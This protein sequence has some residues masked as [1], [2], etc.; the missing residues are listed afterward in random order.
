MHATVESK[1]E[2]DHLREEALAQ[3]G[4]KTTAP[5]AKYCS[6]HLSSAIQREQHCE[7]G[8]RL[9]RTLCLV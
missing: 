7:K 8:V 9:F 4:R 3:H 2:M 1:G 6:N 5:K